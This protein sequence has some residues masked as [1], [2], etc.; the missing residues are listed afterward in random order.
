MLRTLQPGQ[1]CEVWIAS[2]T[3]HSQLVH[4]TDDVLLEAPNW[5]LDGSALILNGD[6]KLWSLDVGT[7]AVAQVPLTGVPDLNN[8]HVLA[9][10]GEQIFL[11]ANDGHIYRAELNGGAAERITNDDGSFHFLHGV[12]P[13][14]QELAYVGIE[15]GD[16]TQP[17]KLMTMASDGGVTAAADVG[18]GHCDGPEYSPDGKWL[19]LNTESFTST[20]G[21]AQ[22]ARIKV[23]GGGFEQL[24]ESETVDWFPHLSPDGRLAS[25]IRFPGG[26]VGHPADL[27]VDVVLVSTGDWTTP[28]HTWSLFGGQGT[29]NV[30]S[31]SP[32]STRF[33]YVAYPLSDSE[34]TKD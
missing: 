14:G 10:D 34:T 21:H 33:A 27:P 20:P 16:F 7:C 24:L 9:P 30:N 23:N 32:G 12:S 11:S 4:T 28:L 3:G 5:T 22:L 17:G 8:D 2:V 1:R 31:W 29:L 26:T 13:D 15:A 6:G 19:Y 18:A 25:Y